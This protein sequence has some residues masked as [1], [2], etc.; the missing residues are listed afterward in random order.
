MHALSY[1]GE[2]NEALGSF[3]EWFKSH[4]EQSCK[5]AL[6]SFCQ[7]KWRCEFRVVKRNRELRCQ[8]LRSGHAK[9]H[10]DG[11]GK[12]IGT[13]PYRSEFSPEQFSSVWTAKIKE[14]LG[15]LEQKFRGKRTKSM[16]LNREEPDDAF[17]IHR[18]QVE[19]FYSQVCRGSYLTNAT[20]LCCLMHTPEFPLKC[21]HALCAEC[22][23]GYD[24]TPQ[25][26]LITIKGCPLHSKGSIE[27]RQISYMKTKPVLAG[28]RVLTLDGYAEQ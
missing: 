27:S 5:T 17:D 8:N 4:Y 21:G 6:T 13:G 16:G 26:G 20:C 1:C 24:A 28:V 14:E 12:I 2:A 7:T 10:Q 25:D 11:K 15:K 3:D 19:E 18:S 22:V 23:R 9:G